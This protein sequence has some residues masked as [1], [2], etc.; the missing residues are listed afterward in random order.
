[1]CS[2]GGVAFG[3]I[4][5]E[6]ISSLKCFLWTKSK[7]L[8]PS[9]MADSER[10]RRA[11]V[12]EAKRAKLAELRALT[13]SRKQ[14]Y[15]WACLPYQCARGWLTCSIANT[16]VTLLLHRRGTTAAAAS[17][18][19][20]VPPA[21]PAPAPAPT[22]APAPSPSP[23]S[24]PAPAPAPDANLDAFIDNLLSAPVPQGANTG[25]STSASAS[26]GAAQ[27]NAAGANEGEVGSAAVAG[28]S[29]DEWRQARRAKLAVVKVC[30][31]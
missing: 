19:P 5:F 10:A 14:G 8:L 30:L 22:P 20:A 1:M 26:S 29:I 27:H 18:T 7:P 6:M 31:Q 2:K 21:P 9:S 13:R 28:P 16:E 24:S 23:T 11:A 4:S 17:P 25:A 12:L 15:V 3:L